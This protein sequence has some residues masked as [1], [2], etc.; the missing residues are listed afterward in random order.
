[1]GPKGT[2]PESGS[3]SVRTIPLGRR[4][5]SE[6]SDAVRNRQRILD[7]AAALIRQ[8]GVDAITMDEVAAA[9]GVGKGT[10]YRRFGDKGGL[11]EALLDR[12]ET[13]LQEAILTGPPPLGPGAD[14]ADRLRAFF[15][16]YA[17]LLE[18]DGRLLLVAETSTPASRYHSGAY[19]FW[20]AHVVALLRRAGAEVD[21]AV[22]GHLLLAG[23]AADLY[24]HLRRGEGRPPGRI[25]EA[26]AD[27]AAAV[28]A[29]PGRR[30]RR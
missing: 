18:W 10:L 4:P 25:A 23:V 9:A 28:A 14:P 11:A 6:R 16:A 12:R 17:D 24:Q 13:E 30:S 26:L 21:A 19:A 7:A 5:R 27:V 1:M 8:R 20:H 15:G 22:V 3:Q 2:G 29:P